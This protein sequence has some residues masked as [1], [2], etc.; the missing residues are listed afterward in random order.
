MPKKPLCDLNSK[1][2]SEKKR[3][4][5]KLE[6]LKNAKGSEIDNKHVE[7]KSVMKVMVADGKQGSRDFGHDKFVSQTA[8]RS[9]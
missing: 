2:D 1:H 3:K 4:S 5:F 9:A 8:D 6:Q 7:D